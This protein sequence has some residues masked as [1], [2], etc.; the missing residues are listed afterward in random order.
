MKVS[1]VRRAHQL[2]VE[3]DKVQRAWTKARSSYAEHSAVVEIKHS[4]DKIDLASLID[5]RSV[6]TTALENRNL[7]LCNQLAALGVVPDVELE[8]AND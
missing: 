6:L 8:D 7:D 3:R 5:V 2:L 4:S 1:D